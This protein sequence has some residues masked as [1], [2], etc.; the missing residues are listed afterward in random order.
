MEEFRFTV[1]DDDGR[2]GP[3]AYLSRAIGALSSQLARELRTRTV[4]PDGRRENVAEHSLMLVKVASSL[5]DEMYPDLDVGQ[6]ALFAA[7]H[8]DVEAYVG[9]TPTDSIAMHDV[10][11]KKRREH[12]A[13]EQIRLEYG[14]VAPKYVERLIAYEKQEIPEARFVRVVDKLMVELI[15][16]PNEGAELKKHYTAAEALKVTKQNASR[17]LGDYP[18]YKDIIDARAE[19]ATYLIDNFLS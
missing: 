11:A 12:R 6:V 17:L 1:P 9:D 8:D 10:A 18:E 16:F 15:H 19:L 5:A 14:G 3:Q 13:L 4:H 7:L 2:L